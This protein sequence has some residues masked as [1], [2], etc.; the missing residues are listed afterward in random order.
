MRGLS[1]EEYV[2]KQLKARSPLEE[3]IR[4]EIPLATRLQVAGH[5]FYLSND[6]ILT[7]RHLKESVHGWCRKGM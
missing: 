7:S 4:S 2:P 5:K 3:Y 1:T 6:G